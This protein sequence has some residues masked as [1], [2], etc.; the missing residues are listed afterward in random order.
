MLD[1]ARAPSLGSA[2]CGWLGAGGC[3]EQQ[4]HG[5]KKKGGLLY[6]GGPLVTRARAF[7]TPKVPPLDARARNERRIDIACH[8]PP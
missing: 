4:L 1:T 7:A 5:S 3:E 8:S 6:N 2:G